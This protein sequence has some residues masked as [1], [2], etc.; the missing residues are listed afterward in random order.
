MNLE[1]AR[2]SA[3]FLAVILAISFLVRLGLTVEHSGSP[4]FEHLRID[5]V[6]YYEWSLE[7]ME[8]RYFLDVV[9]NHAPG[10]PW[11]AGTL[12]RA[13]GES[14][15]VHR[16][17]N[18][19]LGTTTVF[20]VFLIGRELFGRGAALAGA[21]LCGLYW[22]LL[23]FEQR[24]LATSLFVFLCTAGLYIVI[25]AA[26]KDR[27]YWWAL[28]GAVIGYAALVRPTA[29]VFVLF[30]F[31][32][33]LVRAIWKRRFVLILHAAILLAAAAAFILPVA[34]K[35]HSISGQGFLV[36]INAGLNLYL[37]NNEGSNGTPYARLTGTWEKI[38]SM[39]V[40]EEGVYDASAQDKFYIGKVLSYMKEKPL[41]FLLL[42]FK[43]AGLFLNRAEVRATFDPAFL[44]S[45]FYVSWLPFPGFALVLVLFAPGLAAVK[46]REPGHQ[47][48]LIYI[49]G[50]F[51]FTVA[52]V[53]SSR[54]RA[55]V[56][57][58]L[59]A[60]S[61]AGAL[62]L[63]EKAYGL[64]RSRSSPDSKELKKL[65]ALSAA[66]VLAALVTFFPLAPECSHAES[67]TYLGDAWRQAGHDDKAAEFYG[68]ALDAT[69]DYSPALIRI[70][71]MYA[72]S[73]RYAE[74]A[75]WY[76]KAAESKGGNS[77][78]DYR[79]GFVYWKMG[80]SESSVDRLSRTVAARPQ[81]VPGLL[82]LALREWRTGMEDRAK[83]HL[84]TIL[85]LRPA[86]TDARKLLGMIEQGV[87]PP[88]PPRYDKDKGRV[89]SP[90]E[91]EKQRRSGP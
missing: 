86:H 5:E 33:L 20:F 39:P 36:Q 1:S 79:L 54:Y 8:D 90:L 37:G 18:I 63:G 44:R 68:K 34:A 17:L 48:L 59:C 89:V 69:E 31:A 67:F 29:A 27:W 80:M 42:Q 26:R 88:P 40:K 19:V 85:K 84:R 57:P 38:E 76:K 53:V 24:M 41:D 78:A 60:V 58:A 14:M 87:K 23:I 73:N 72:D 21:L 45:L 13:F 49:L 75:R 61:G 83:D 62:L 46:P 16:L 70:G 77:L 10:Y 4:L 2:D 35:N 25:L 64:V 32:W 66:A 15:W 81:W 91:Q 43:K 47:A 50:F 82:Q 51:L 11:V 74:A 56:M 12:Y 52:T 28:A 65:G 22:P 3:V 7:V 6:G 9:P 71:D 55:P 30:V